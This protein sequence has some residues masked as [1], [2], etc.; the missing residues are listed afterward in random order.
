MRGKGPI[1]DFSS[2]PSS[3]RKVD[4]DRLQRILDG[5]VEELNKYAREKGEEFAKGKKRDRLSASQ[6]RSVLDEIQRMN[7]YDKRKLHLLRPKLAYAAGRHKGKVVN[8]QE[9]MDTAILMVNESNFEYFRD[10][11]EAIVAY[12]RYY[13]E[14]ESE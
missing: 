13:I 2:I 3:V 12:H 8:F 10:F 11:V 5:D 1:K 9:L 14:G 4:R 7:R 6:I